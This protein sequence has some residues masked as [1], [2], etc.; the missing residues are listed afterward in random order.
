MKN[1]Q[2][3]LDEDTLSRVDRAA[4][5]LGLTRSQIVRE[6]LREWLQRKAVNAFESEWIASLEAKPDDAGRAEAWSSAQTW[7]KP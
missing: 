1:V 4:A 3:S 7:N 2:V 5:P 6:A